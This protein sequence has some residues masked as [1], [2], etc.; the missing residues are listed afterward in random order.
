MLPHLLT[1]II[2]FNKHSSLKNHEYFVI[3]FRANMATLFQIH[4]NIIKV[5]FG[6]LKIS[7]KRAL[8]KQKAGATEKE[9]ANYDSLSQITIRFHPI[10][11]CN[12]DF[13]MNS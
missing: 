1:S 2:P 6:D 12:H 3:V 11:K 8:S 5:A 4:C 9:E 10:L 13:V 7:C